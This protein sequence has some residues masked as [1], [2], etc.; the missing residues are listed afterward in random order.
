MSRQIVPK[1]GDEKKLLRRGQ[2]IHIRNGF[3]DHA[4]QNTARRFQD[5]PR[6]DRLKPI[7]GMKLLNG[8]EKALQGYTYLTLDGN[9]NGKH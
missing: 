6:G 1:L 2:P 8:C 9:G 3:E 4:A 7:D 5:K